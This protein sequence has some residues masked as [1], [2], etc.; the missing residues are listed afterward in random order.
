MQQE[1]VGV[2]VVTKQDVLDVLRGLPDEFD[3]EELL[4]RLYVLRKIHQGEQAIEEGRVVS[5]EEAKRRMR[6][7]LA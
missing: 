6:S 5:H 1:M 7:W 4:Y 2:G 3:S